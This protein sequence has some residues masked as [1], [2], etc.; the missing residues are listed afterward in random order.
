[1]DWVAWAAAVVDFLAA[2]VVILVVA[3][4]R[5][6]GNEASSILL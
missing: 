3:V 6:I 1:V 5:G 2:V 4:P